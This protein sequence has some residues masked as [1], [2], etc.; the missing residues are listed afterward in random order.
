MSGLKEKIFLSGFEKLWTLPRKF[1]HK[2]RKMQGQ[3]RVWLH[4]D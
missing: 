4:A 3:V 2:V 1:K